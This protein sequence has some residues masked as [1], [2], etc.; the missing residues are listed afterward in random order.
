M[1]DYLSIPEFY[2]R[3]PNEES[4]R[5]YI[6]EQRWNGKPCCSRCGSTKVWKIKS[7]MGYKCG[8]CPKSKAEFSVRT[9]TIMEYSRVSLQKWLLAMN[10]MTTA[11]K[12]FS[13][14]QFAKHLGV[15]QKTAWSMEHRIRKACEM[16]EEEPLTG[17]V[18][19]DSTYIGGKCKNMSNAKR[20]ALEDTGRGT[21]GK[22]AVV[23]IQERGGK[24]VAQHVEQEDMETLYPL[25]EKN[26][27]EGSSVY[28][29]E[30]KVF[31]QLHKAFDHES[32]KHSA[33]EYVK[34]NA[35]TNSIES[36]W[37]LLK[38]GYYGT[39]HTGGASNTCTVMSLNTSI[40]RIRVISL[41]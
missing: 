38:R 19:V 39:H 24:V 16:N 13:S 41:D 1:S 4:A 9:G 30:H 17:K 15:T 5:E 40:G 33:S 32:V 14:V 25:I 28:T 35:S 26:V 20:K 36:F 11:R 21:V 29:D 34:G 3:F 31:S 23:G 12:G 2:E 37:V 10:M 8:D 6:A 18:E 22:A 7:G 27:E